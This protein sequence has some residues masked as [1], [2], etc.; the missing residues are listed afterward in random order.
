MGGSWGDTSSISG[1][2]Q[3]VLRKE[4]GTFSLSPGKFEAEGFSER[5]WLYGLDV[6]YQF[7]PL[8]I[9]AAVIG[10]ISKIFRRQ[11]E[12]VV[13]LSAL[14]FYLVIFHSLSNLPL[15]S[16]MPFEVHRRFWMQPNIIVCVFLG[17]GLHAWIEKA[18]LRQS[19]LWSLLPIV[20]FS[21]ALLWQ[22]GQL[23]TRMRQFNGDGGS[24]FEDFG[25]E[26]LQSVPHENSLLISTTDINWNSVRYLQLCEYSRQNLSHVSLQ[27]AA[28]PWFQRQKHLYSGV[29]FPA[30]LADASMQKGTP[31][32]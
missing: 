21:S 6:S 25:H 5:T 29:E 1:V 19:I 8:G 11:T 13:L 16:P 10:V 22:K 17:F 15:S 20:G 24:Y 27:V 7:G 28:F 23:F 2:F 30:V 12:G 18:A 9:S 31:G 14:G 3:H 26:I 32:H 4:Y